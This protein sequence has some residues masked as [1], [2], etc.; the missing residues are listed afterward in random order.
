MCAILLQ[1]LLGPSV[2]WRSSVGEEDLGRRVSGE[3]G[4]NCMDGLSAGVLDDCYLWVPCEEIDEYQDVLIV[5]GRA[6]V[7]TS[8]VFHRLGGHRGGL[9]GVPVVCWCG[10]LAL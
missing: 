3:D 5:W 10:G 4:V 9:Q 7:V 6:P 2:P 1:G 8:Q